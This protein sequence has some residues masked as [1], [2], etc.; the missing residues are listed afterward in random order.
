[1]TLRCDFALRQ[2]LSAV[3]DG[4]RNMV[5]VPETHA[6]VWLSQLVHVF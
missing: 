3:Y 5:V 1:M 6:K 2:G 4:V